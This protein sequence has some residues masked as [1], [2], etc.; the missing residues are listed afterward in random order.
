[1]QWG[2]DF[3]E[4]E[5]QQGRRTLWAPCQG[6]GGSVSLRSW[7]LEQAG[8]ALGRGG[9][10]DAPTLISGAADN[11]VIAD[12]ASADT[13]S[14]TWL[15]ELLACAQVADG[16]TSTPP[17]PRLVILLPLKAAM[18]PHL[19]PFLERLHTLGAVD[20]RPPGKDAEIA[21]DEY[22]AALSSLPAGAGALPA[23]IALSPIPL[24]RVQ[25]E[26]LAAACGASPEFAQAILKSDLLFSAEAHFVVD[27]SSARRLLLA[28]A[29][30]KVRERA[31]RTLLEVCEKEFENLPDA[32]VELLKHAGET[33]QAT[34]LA[35][36]RFEDHFNSGRN[37]EALRILRIAHE[38]GIS[39]ENV[40]QAEDFDQAKLAALYALQGQYARAQDT[41]Q[42]LLRKRRLLED[43]QFVE[44]IAI[45]CRELAMYAGF[46]KRV[47]DSMLRRAIRLAAASLD[48]TYRLQILRVGLLRSRAFKL[49][50]RA[51]WLFSHI[52]QGSLDKVSRGTL[53]LYYHAAATR[54]IDRGAYKAAFRQLRKLTS[55]AF[56]DQQAGEGYSMMARCRLHFGDR[57][58]AQR[59][60]SAALQFGLRGAELRLVQEAAQILREIGQRTDRPT[61]LNGKKQARKGEPETPRSA[62]P[63]KLFGI[64][65]HRFGAVYW[66]RRRHG[67][68]KEF[69]K[70][71]GADPQ[72]LA[73]F[74]ERTGR[75]IRINS[76][77]GAGLRALI[78]MRAEGDDTVIF[79]PRPEGGRAED[80]IMRF[81]QADHDVASAEKPAAMPRRREVIEDYLKRITEHDPAKGLYDALEALFAKDVLLHLEDLGVP[82]EEMAGK[83]G[84]S[85]ATLYRM[86]ARCG[87]N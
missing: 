2:A 59:Y 41:L 15:V 71:P 39:M 69:G 50:E 33:R 70:H 25:Y 28:G 82:K 86:F 5:R 62:D 87:L 12:P 67:Q 3:S 56:S 74:T 34:R 6:L 9:L 42:P 58:G 83:L 75:A 47:A 27:S 30:E 79:P 21:E 57:D 60:A 77:E 53:A 16:L 38:L 10:V 20:I 7:I 85:R 11:L 8:E 45:C 68:L 35:K 40:P 84:V 37:A 13:E 1:M 52:H 54:Q 72:G 36:R 31:A 32:R 26:R 63:A 66:A 22:E 51:D 44:W 80:G 46:D 19:E 43:P 55:L 48:R 18:P 29:D 78:F 76:A 49:N 4:R 14:L 61:H 23:A 73:V 65:E 17:L 24:T 81:L 64:L